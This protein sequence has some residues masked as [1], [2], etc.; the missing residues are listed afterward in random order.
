MPEAFSSGPPPAPASPRVQARAWRCAPDAVFSADA[1]GAPDPRLAVPLPLPPPPLPLAAVRLALV[2][3]RAAVLRGQ[4][5]PHQ[6]LLRPRVSRLRSRSLRCLLRTKPMIRP[7]KLACRVRAR[8]PPARRAGVGDV[9]EHQHA[10]QAAAGRPHN[11][12]VPQLS[13]LLAASSQ[14]QQLAAME[15]IIEARKR[16][17]GGFLGP[18]RTGQEADVEPENR[19]GTVPQAAQRPRST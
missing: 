7:V 14:P 3:G 10:R 12:P 2:R 16:A 17:R 4:L 6:L 9:R 15:R 1:V 5:D 19:R 18:L 8:R 11:D 13:A